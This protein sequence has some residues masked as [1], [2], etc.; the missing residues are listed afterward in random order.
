MKVLVGFA[1]VVTG[2][3]WATQAQSN[4][5]GS[6][7]SFP[8]PLYDAM[9]SMYGKETGVKVNFESSNS[10]LGQL[11]ILERKVDFAASDAFLTNEQLKSAPA[12]MLHIPMAMASVVPVYNLPNLSSPLKLTGDALARL[13][14]GSIKRWNDPAVQQLNP[15]VALP[16]LPVI[17]IYRSDG[18]GTT[19]IF[20]DFL[21]KASTTWAQTVSRG[22]QTSVKWP[23]GIGADKTDGLVQQVRQRIGSI[24]YLAISSAKSNKLSYAWVANRAGAFVDGGDLGQLANA[25]NVA[26][27]PDD[28]RVSITDAD[29][30]YPISG[31]TWVLVY[32]DQKYNNRSLGQAKTLVKLLRWMIDDGQ[33]LNPRLNYGQVD[34]P[35]AARAFRLIESMT[36][37][38]QKL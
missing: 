2:S 13:Y 19:S 18:S 9:F 4:I 24:G 21:A 29:I 36:Y 15:G 32:R 25:A 16:D 7:A 35:A 5:L 31:F 8:A 26:S 30:G 37:G 12:P 10:R 22:P 3:L 1:L 17:P 27:I 38:G 23:V 6:G 33:R 20:V 14:L 28:I 34:G 11:S